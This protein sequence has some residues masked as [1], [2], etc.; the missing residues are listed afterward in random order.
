MN[1]IKI[2][3][4]DCDGVMFDS[5]NLNRVYYNAMLSRFDLPEMTDEQLE[6]VHMHTVK[7]AI[8][9]LF[10]GKRDIDEVLSFRNSINYA[11]LLQHMTMEPGLREILKKLRMKYKTAIATS[12]SDTMGILL[13]E[14]NLADDFD[15]VVTS[16][17]VSRPKPFPDQLDKILRHFG[18]A[19]EEALYIGDSAMDEG[20]AI[21]AGVPFI[22]YRNSSLAALAHIDEL[23]QLEEIL[24]LNGY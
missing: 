16:L 3:I 8:L 6:Y 24:A 14:H 18:L 9:Y 11:G 21:A 2:I 4:F 5:I 20:A 15:M 10:E 13:D 23:M 19:P 1:N 17:D 12:R 22:A 7:E